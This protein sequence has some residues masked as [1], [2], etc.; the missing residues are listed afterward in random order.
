MIF[1]VRDA[2]L[3]VLLIERG[4]PPFEGDFALPGGYVRE[5]EDLDQAALRELAE[6]TGVTGLYLEQLRTFGAPDRDPRGRTFTVA[7][8]ALGPDLPT[9]VA[10]TDAAK[11]HWVPIETALSYELAF[12]H[13]AILKEG[14]DR[15]RA[16]L[17]YTTVA[18]AFCREPF[19]IAELR[20]VYEVIWGFPLDPSNFRR[21]VTK[22]ADF[23]E[24]TG[25]FRT[26]ETGRP[27]ALYRRGSAALLFP[28][29]PRSGDV[30]REAYP[31]PVTA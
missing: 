14:L 12:D 17:E 15:A 13:M 10:G 1:T 19:T 30:G 22:A 9:P 11:A 8:L 4:K 5:G 26:P 16:K 3:R 29:M 6:E 24:R 31:S 7:Y 18:A 28:P 27:A 20:H 2:S 21:K 25:E 23:V